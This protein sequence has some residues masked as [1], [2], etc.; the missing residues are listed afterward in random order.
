MMAIVALFMLL[1]PGLV[2]VSILWHKKDIRREDYK[3]VA[4]DYVIHS[5]LIQTA[6]YGFMF[7]TYPERT[8]SFAAAEAASH[9]LSASFVFKYSVS[10][11]AA[12]VAIPVSMHLAAR[13]WQSLNDERGKKRKKG[14]KS[15]YRRRPSTHEHRS[16]LRRQR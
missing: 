10:A 2:A 4:R 14:R 13:F 1:A 7:I 9:I 3:I 6:V 12:A 11:F 15:A 8:V 5:F 16:S